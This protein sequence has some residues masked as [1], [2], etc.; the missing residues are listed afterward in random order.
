MENSRNGNVSGRVLVEPSMNNTSAPTGTAGIENFP[1][2]SVRAE[3]LVPLIL[4]VAFGIGWFALS[5]T[6]PLTAVLAG[7]FGVVPE[8]IKVAG[9]S[10][11]PA[12]EARTVLL[13]MPSSCASE[14]T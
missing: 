2:A 3:R 1:L 7:F 11:S 6:I 10:V 4:A 14:S 5:R 12:K 8:A 13:L 9:V